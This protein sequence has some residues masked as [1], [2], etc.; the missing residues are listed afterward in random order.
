MIDENI[1]SLI[2]LAMNGMQ[3][4][5]SAFQQVRN[6]GSY[7]T[8]KLINLTDVELEAKLDETKGT[9]E[10]TIGKLIIAE[11]VMQEQNRLSK[12]EY[13]KKTC[14]DEYLELCETLQHHIIEKN[15]K[16]KTGAKS[17]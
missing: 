4:A 17:G 8:R 3:R 2:N 10:A 9:I 12:L 5:A 14:W 6:A 1:R 7:K 16:A 15:S 11:H 13:N